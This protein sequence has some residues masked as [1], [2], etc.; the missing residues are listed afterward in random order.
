LKKIGFIGLG[1]MGGPMAEH[2]LNA[3]YELTVYNRTLSK[4]NHLAEKGAKIAR[5]PADVARASEVLKE[6]NC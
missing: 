2:L 3:G 6:N 4:A 5:C 1:I